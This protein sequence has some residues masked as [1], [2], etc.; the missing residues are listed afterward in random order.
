MVVFDVV[1]RYLRYR[2]Y[3][4]TYVRNITDIDDKIIRRA[5]ENG[6]P[7]EALTARFIA[8]MHEDCARWASSRPI[9]SRAPPQYV[10]QMLAMIG[11]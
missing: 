8:A 10:P 5:A 7:I 9:T 11:N 4:V 2:G 1:R 3:R 6:E